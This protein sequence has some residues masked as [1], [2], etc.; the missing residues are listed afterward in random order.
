MYTTL[1]SI[2]LGAILGAWARY[3]LSLAL[4]DKSWLPWGTFAANAIGGLLVGLALA[5]VAA[6]P[7]L[8]PLWR[9]FFITGFLGAL[10]TFSTFS[11]EVTTLMMNG[12]MLRGIALAAMH[13]IASLALTAVG[14]YSYRV[15]AS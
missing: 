8:S 9:L 14:I 13:L 10:T 15:I 5:H 1:A 12:A 3:G 4:N 11:A 6:K 7:D 2:A